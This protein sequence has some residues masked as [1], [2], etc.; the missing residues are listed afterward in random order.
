MTFATRLQAVRTHDERGASPAS[1]IMLM[2]ALLMFTELIVLGGRVA[3]AHNDVSGAA[4]EAARQ[5]SVLQYSG[6]VTTV[7]EQT[8]M[9]NLDTTSEHCTSPDVS[10]RGTSFRQGGHVRVEVSCTVDLGDFSIMAIPWPTRAFTA[11][12]VEVVETYRAV[13]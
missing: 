3:A 8:A 4:R 13:D 5:A 7:A 11:E 6:S 10:T 2:T 12:A 9:A 1:V